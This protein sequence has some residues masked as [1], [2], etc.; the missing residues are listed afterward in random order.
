MLWPIYISSSTHSFDPS[1]HLFACYLL[2]Y[3]RHNIM[4]QGKP[5]FV[6]LGATGN[7]GGSI[8]AHILLLSTSPY[9]L[10]AVTWDPFFAKAALF[11]SKGV[12]VVSGDFDNPQSL[13]AAFSGVSIIFSITN[14]YHSILN[15]LLRQEATAAGVSGGVLVRDYK[16][17]QNRSIIDAAAEMQVTINAL[18]SNTVQTGRARRRWPFHSAS[19]RVGRRQVP[20][21]NSWLRPRSHKISPEFLVWTHLTSVRFLL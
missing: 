1:S 8:M 3:L 16:A 17:Q 2:S 11:A 9:L 14:F 6:V 10:R 18:G 13:D 7:Q 15:P 19:M 12:E 20:K 21:T 4:S 5:I